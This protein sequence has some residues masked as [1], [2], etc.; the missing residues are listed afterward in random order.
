MFCYP[1]VSGG[2]GQGPMTSSLDAW[3]ALASSS[4]PKAWDLG[5]ARVR[6]VAERLDILQPA[7]GIILVAGT[8]GK[9]SVLAALERLSLGAGFRTGATSSPH[10]I[11]FNERVL[12]DGLPAADEELVQAFARVE[13]A[14]G[15]TTLTY[16]EYASLVAFL[17]FRARQVEIALI[18]IG[19]G[20]RLDAMNMVEPDLSLVTNVSLDHQDYLG[21][22]TEAI[23]REKAHVYRPQKPALFGAEEIPDSV[24]AH[25]SATGAKLLCLGRD[26]WLQ[27]NS[28]C[29]STE[30]GMEA[31]Q[32]PEHLG[33]P[34]DMAALA[35]AAW[36]WSGFE[37]SPKDPGRRLHGLALPARRQLV[38]LQDR[39]FLLDVAHNPA[40][41]E[42]LAGSVAEWRA[43]HPEARVWT[44]LGILADKDIR[45]VVECLRPVTDVWFCAGLPGPRG[46]AAESLAK[47]VKPSPVAGSCATV[48][49]ALAA[50][51]ARSCPR[52]LLVV[53]GSF[54]TA[55]AAMQYLGLDA[56]PSAVEGHWNHGS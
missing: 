50:A 48:D 16:F 5:L 30:S 45:S 23:G 41:A 55:G 43:K 9:G 28:V 53:A 44:L 34:R 3:L 22:T 36:Y 40:S 15:E 4:H 19:L 54:V 7:P 49:A 20:G 52:D 46:L 2:T 21:D 14:R 37:Q 12:I 26:Y 51:I 17:V 29:F 42:L 25:A 47:Q 1:G 31:C 32:L 6:R 27:D 11:R 56:M 39:T 13:E 33:I 38:K 24:V 18:E 35:V 8:N 10:L